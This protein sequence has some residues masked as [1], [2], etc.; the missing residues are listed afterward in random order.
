MPTVYGKKTPQMKLH[1]HSHVVVVIGWVWS[2]RNVKVPHTSAARAAADFGSSPEA[3]ATV[4]STR[5]CVGVGVYD[6]FFGAGAEV[7][8][9]TGLAAG[10]LSRVRP[11]PAKLPDSLPKQLP[12]FSF[13]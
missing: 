11:L 10:V 5:P 8:T 1:P 6:D 9:M 2:G 13:V 7:L 3:S 4:P 12:I